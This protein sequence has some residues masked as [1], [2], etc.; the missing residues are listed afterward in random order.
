MTKKE[1]ILYIFP[2][3]TCVVVEIVKDCVPLVTYLN[4][5]PEMS[6]WYRDLHKTL[7]YIPQ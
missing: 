2:T 5:R 3:K 1:V 6:H 7:T 4:G